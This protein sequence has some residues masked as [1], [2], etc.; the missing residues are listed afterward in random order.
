MKKFLIGCLGVILLV[1][2]VGGILGYQFIYKPGKQF[3]GDLQQLEQIT[4][5]DKKINNHNSFSIPTDNLLTAEQV[6]RYINVQKM[7]EDS[8]ESDFDILNEKYKDIQYGGNVN[9]VR[10]FF[11]TYSDM[12]RI[13]LN[14]KKSQVEALNSNN[15][16]LDEYNWVKK[17]V[18]AAVGQNISSLDLS[19]IADGKSVPVKI[20]L[21][22]DIPEQNVELLK[23]YKDNFEE[24]L[25]FAFFGL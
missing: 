5:L 25:G 16:S 19:K 9:D 3:I 23:K 13:V 8:L 21:P 15:F 20:A 1:S 17:Q 18:L 7:M 10:K 4:E 6:D 12:I 2:I 22:K 24:Y 14:A 11:A